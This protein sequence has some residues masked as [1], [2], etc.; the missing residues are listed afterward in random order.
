MIWALTRSARAAQSRGRGWLERHGGD[1]AADTVTVNGTN[2]VGQTTN[3]TSFSF[4]LSNC[5]PNHYVFAA[6][7]TDN[8]GLTNMQEY[9]RGTR[10]NLPDTDGDGLNDG[11]EVAGAGSRP[12]TSCGHRPCWRQYK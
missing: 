4:T 1:G 10:A 12:P 3:A 8:D 5:A 6:L 7:A 11:A 9:Q 2:V